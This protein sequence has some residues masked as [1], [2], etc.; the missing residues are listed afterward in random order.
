MSVKKPPPLPGKQKL[1]SEP[2][3]NP[4]EA[5]KPDEDV[6]PFETVKVVDEVNPFEAAKTSHQAKYFLFRFSIIINFLMYLKANLHQAF[7]PKQKLP[8]RSLENQL[9]LS[10]CLNLFQNSSSIS[11]W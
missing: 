2:D 8:L 6:N 3:V 5:A 10:Y 11:K 7:P 1:P 4:F 9:L